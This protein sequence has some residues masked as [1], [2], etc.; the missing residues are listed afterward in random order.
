MLL[1]DMDTE[2]LLTLLNDCRQEEV[3]QLEHQL[4]RLQ[5]A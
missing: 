1:P 5:A 2:T 3:L 4:A